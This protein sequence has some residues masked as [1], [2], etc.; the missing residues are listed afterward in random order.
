MNDPKPPASQDATL[1]RDQLWLMVLPLA[2]L[3][4]AW[5]APPP[6]LA[7][8]SGTWSRGVQASASSSQNLW[9]V[10]LLP[11]QHI[12]AQRLIEA[13]SQ[14]ADPTTHL[15]TSADAHG[16][17]IAG[18]P[19]E[20]RRLIKLAHKLDQ[21]LSDDEQIWAHRVRYTKAHD[22]IPLLERALA[23]F[24]SRRHCTPPQ[25]VV[26]RLLVDDVTNALLVVTNTHEQA[27]LERIM[28]I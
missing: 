8:A 1:R 16:V 13:L 22:V 4:I 27:H 19:L 14:I 15:S 3:A 2:V 25:P 28:A 7:N 11:L 23:R 20:V 17:L 18:H 10:K 5:Q 24:A 6:G 12:D 9:G 26:S 21:P